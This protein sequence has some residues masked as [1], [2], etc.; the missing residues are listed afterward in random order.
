MAEPD[1]T[2]IGGDRIQPVRQ[3]RPVVSSLDTWDQNT[4]IDY[5][6]PAHVVGRRPA[7]NVPSLAVTAE[8]INTIQQN[9]RTRYVAP[10][11]AVRVVQ[12]YSPQSN[13][14]VWKV[15]PNMAQNIYT[16]S[17]VHI[18]FS[19]NVA[20]GTANDS[21]QF[22]IYRDGVKISQIFSTTTPAAN[23]P[24]LVSGSYIDTKPSM[25]TTHVYDLRWKRGNSPL[26]AFGKDRTFQ[27]SNLRAQ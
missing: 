15:V 23:H 8:S 27:A 11:T 18:V 10:T 14:A 2:L 20:T 4:Q 16:D 12:P 1:E 17:H 5:P 3:P 6:F 13:V 24:V 19:I 25:R 7:W 9:Q 21:P 22:A 26:V